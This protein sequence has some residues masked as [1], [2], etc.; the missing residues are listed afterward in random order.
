[1]TKA[2]IN[3]MVKWMADDF[4]ADN[5]RINAIGPGMV[6]SEMTKPLIDMGIVKNEQGKFI[7]EPENVASVAAMICSKDGSFVNG[8][9]YNIHAGITKI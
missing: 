2:A 1:M 7:A 5:I 3:N 9:I 4:R 6:R 8:E